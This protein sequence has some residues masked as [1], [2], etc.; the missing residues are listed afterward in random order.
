MK[1]VGGSLVFGKYL[2]QGVITP[3]GAGAI[4]PQGWAFVRNR[5]DMG[6]VDGKINTQTDDPSWVPDPSYALYLDTVPNNDAIYD[7]DGPNGG[8]VGS[9][10]PMYCEEEF[11]NFEEWVTWGSV[12]VSATAYF[13][14]NVGWSSDM[15]P[16]IYMASLSLDSS[17]PPPPPPALPTK[18]DDNCNTLT[19]A[20]PTFS[21]AGGAYTASQSVKISDSDTSTTVQIFY[22][23]DGSTPSSGSTLYSGPITVSSTETISAIAVGSSAGSVEN[24]SAPATATYTITTG[25]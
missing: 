6:W 23:T 2:A 7:T 17:G 16:G 20:T 8:R 3:Q 19:T 10:L 24:P 14:W 21:P 13:S 12:T 9:P 22:T 25:H 4:V 5:E 1:P 15:D 11:V 18:P